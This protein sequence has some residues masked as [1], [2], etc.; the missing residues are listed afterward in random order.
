MTNTLIQELREIRDSHS[1]IR[2]LVRKDLFG[3]YKNSAMGF[4]WHFIIPIVMMI[5]YY[6]VFQTIRT[7]A[8]PHFWVFLASGLFPFNFM[9]TNLNRGPGM[10]VSN[11]AMVKKMYFPRS[12]LVISEVLS[13]FLIMLMGYGAILIAICLSGYPITYA[14]LLLPV[15]LVPMIVMVLGYSLVLSAI[16]VYVKDIQHLVNSLSMVFYFI[17]PMYFSLGDVSGIFGTIILINPFTY[18]IESFHQIIYN[19]VIPGAD[20][21]IVCFLV[22]IAFLVAGVLVFHRLKRGFAERL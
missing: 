1:V 5:V 18:F 11:S 10:I 22:P 9:M 6:V 14:I 12:I 15:L 4:A 2:G 17:T 20:L 3:R 13:S 7:N 19:G 21:L 8:I 16:T